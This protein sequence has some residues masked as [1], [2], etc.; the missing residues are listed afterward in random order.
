MRFAYIDSQGREVN[1]PSVDALRLRIELGAIKDTTEF[2]DANTGKWGPAGEHEIYRTLQRELTELESGGF[3]PPPS[4]PE[5]STPEPPAA[6]DPVD[7]PP[8]EESLTDE[9]PAMTPPEPMPPVEETA[10]AELPPEEPAEEPALPDDGGLGEITMGAEVEATP[11]E[12]VGDGDDL[13]LGFDLDL[14]PTDIPAAEPAGEEMPSM[15]VTSSADELM[16]GDED[17]PPPP[18]AAEEAGAET[19]QL[20]SMENLEDLASMELSDEWGEDDGP[21]NFAGASESAPSDLGGLE[22]DPVD[23]DSSWEPP[24]P[25]PDTGLDLEAPLTDYEADQP[26]AWMQEG[27]ETEEWAGGEEDATLPPFRANCLSVFQEV[28]DD[29]ANTPPH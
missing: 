12:P 5:A 13:G 25:P 3:V 17:A 10:A 22:L 14:A 6:P 26:P 28:P 11:M 24:P 4:V 1:I 23:S 8:A 9:L 20:P 29:A 27:S 16:G 2:H 15:D 18:P 7:G 21:P 19:P